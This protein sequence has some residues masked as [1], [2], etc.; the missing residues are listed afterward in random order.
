MVTGSA[1]GPP[2][3]W[4]KRTQDGHP[5]S[6]YS[7]TLL[8]RDTQF[9]PHTQVHS[10]EGTLKKLQGSTTGDQREMQK[11]MGLIV[12]CA[13]MWKTMFLPVVGPVPGQISQLA[14]LPGESPF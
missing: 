2:L 5:A 14:A 12:A 9:L 11:G 1:R 13:H 8:G 3:W 7:E 4:E 10:G 6:S